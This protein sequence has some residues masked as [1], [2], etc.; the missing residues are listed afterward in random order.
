MKIKLSDIAPPA[1]YVRE[2]IKPARIQDFVRIGAQLTPDQEIPKKPKL[3]LWP[4]PP[5]LV[6]QIKKDPSLKKQKPFELIDGG[7]RLKVAK[8]FGLKD[9]P[10]E[11]SPVQTAGKAFLL[12]IKTADN[13]PLPLS[14]R[15]RAQAIW[16]L[17]HEFKMTQEQI[18]KEFGYHRSQISRFCSK[19]SGWG[20]KPGRKVGQKPSKSA[21]PITIKGS[22]LTP[23][24]WFE[25]LQMILIMYEKE[26]EA[27][28]FTKYLE[29]FSE[30]KIAKFYDLISSVSDSINEICKEKLKA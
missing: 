9:I 2:G 17:Y 1:N 20:D 21:E 18:G 22:A 28:L 29:S 19:K 10:G 8:I 13:G 15:E 6:R 4:F 24:E 27:L 30:V 16:T 5:I 25:R 3:I 12:Q 26:G 23:S 7:H 14:N 11:I